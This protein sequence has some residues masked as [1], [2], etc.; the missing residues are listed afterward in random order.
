MVHMRTRSRRRDKSTTRR[1]HQNTVDD[2]HLSAVGVMPSFT[3]IPHPWD[4]VHAEKADNSR[5][6]NEVRGSFAAGFRV[7]IAI[8]RGLVRSQT[9]AAWPNWR[10]CESLILPH[11]HSNMLS[12]Q[13]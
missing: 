9:E 3:V 12:L 7:V 2:A 5:A 10:I 6:Y 1:K 4:R 11:M 13:G 8:V